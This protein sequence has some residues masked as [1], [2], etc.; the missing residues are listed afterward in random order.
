MQD[1]SLD[2]GGVTL[3]IILGFL[4]GPALFYAFFGD[5]WHSTGLHFSRG[6]A[7]GVGGVLALAAL[8]NAT[9][10]RNAGVAGALAGFAG[11]AGEFAVAIV[12][13]FGLNYTHPTCSS[14]NLCPIFAPNDLAQL[15]LTVAIFCGVVFTLAGYSLAALV[16]G[17]RAQLR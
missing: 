4:A 10:F 15:A 17:V 5:Y 6:I 11:A 16:A 13:W 2:A 12:P 14:G 8:A 9:R 7:G 1:R 3:A